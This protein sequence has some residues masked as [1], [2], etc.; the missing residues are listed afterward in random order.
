MVVGISRRWPGVL[1]SGAV[2]IGQGSNTIM[3]QIAADALGVPAADV[4][5]VAGDTDRTRDAG[6]TRCLAADFLSGNAAKQ[7]GEALR[8]EILRRANVGRCD[9]LRWSTARFA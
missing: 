6:K 8:A 5:L 4:G 3:V 9:T 1:F 2:D 7:A